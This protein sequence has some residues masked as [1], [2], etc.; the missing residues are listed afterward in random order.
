VILQ[1]LKLYLT[2]IIIS[3]KKIKNTNIK[4]FIYTKLE[5]FSI[6]FYNNV[7]Y[8][9]LFLHI[10]QLGEN[11]NHAMSKLTSKSDKTDGE[12]KK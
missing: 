5:Y 12:S 10:L 3:C 6:S 9:Q 8:N 4:D 2:F 7:Q 1:R 11:Y